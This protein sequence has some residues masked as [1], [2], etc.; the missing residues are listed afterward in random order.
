MAMGRRCQQ[1]PWPWPIVSFSCFEAKILSA[2]STYT[3]QSF[4]TGLNSKITV[5][6]CGLSLLPQ[7]KITLQSPNGFALKFAW[8]I[9]EGKQA[10]VPVYGLGF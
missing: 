1:D 5:D 10:G 3:Y 8:S 9:V 4:S 7:K 2:P 6:I